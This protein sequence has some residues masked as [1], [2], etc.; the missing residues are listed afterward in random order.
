M[1]I[2]SIS[3]TWASLEHGHPVLCLFESLRQ[4]LYGPQSL[5]C[6]FSGPSQICPSPVERNTSLKAALP[7]LTTQAG[8]QVPE[9]QQGEVTV[10][11]SKPSW[12]V[13]MGILPSL[14]PYTPISAESQMVFILL[15]PPLSFWDH[16]MSPCRKHICDHTATYLSAA[17]RRGPRAGWREESCLQRAS[18]LSPW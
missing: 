14:G 8:G 12:Q 3:K 2:S 18:E 5:E 17:Q 10:P 13:S 9:L 16:G 1:H 6:L 15:C 4:R 11:H 7:E